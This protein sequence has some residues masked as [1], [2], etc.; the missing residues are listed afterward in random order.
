[1]SS[2][3]TYDFGSGLVRAHRH[4][5]VDGSLGGWVADTAS[6]RPEVWMDPTAKVSGYA[7][8]VGFTKL[9]GN[10]HVYGN[11]VIES[12]SNLEFITISGNA[13]VFGFSRITDASFVL[14]DAR[15]YGNSRVADHSCIRNNAQV[16][17]TARVVESSSIAGNAKIY[18]N[19]CIM[20]RSV[21]FEDAQ[22]YDN[23][24]VSG[25]AL[26]SGTTIINGVMSVHQESANG[27]PVYK[28]YADQD[29][30]LSF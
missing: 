9:F 26:I 23:A 18:G 12:A 5:N 22:I 20:G 6:V 1:M 16:F 4:K 28:G 25:F 11:A 21:I 27:H 13:K 17:G 7:V 24:N 8:I 3:E 30:L 10:P 19:S 29:T 15:V 14:D 2:Y